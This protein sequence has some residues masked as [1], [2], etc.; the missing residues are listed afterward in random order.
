MGGGLSLPLT[1]PPPSSTPQ[2][3]LMGAMRES[4]VAQRFPQFVRRFL[5]TMYG[6]GRGGPPRWVLEAL[7]SVGITLD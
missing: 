6:G 3:N 1:P 4:I 2:L 7:G 5:D